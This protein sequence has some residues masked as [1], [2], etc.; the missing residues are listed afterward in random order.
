MTTQNSFFNSQDPIITMML[1]V[2]VNNNNKEN[3][4]TMSNLSSCCNQLERVSLARWTP[5][6]YKIGG[7]SQFG[8]S[9]L[10]TPR[11]CVGSTP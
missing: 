8:K 3:K 6:L 5:S 1:Y 2:I 9:P 10:R 11:R 7:H 4:R